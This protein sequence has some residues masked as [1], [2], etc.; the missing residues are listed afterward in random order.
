MGIRSVIVVRRDRLAWLDFA[1]RP[2][3]A[4]RTRVT[5]FRLGCWRAMA[6]GCPLFA[7][8]QRCGHAQRLSLCSRARRPSLIMRPVRPEKSTDLVTPTVGTLLTTFAKAGEVTKA[9]RGYRLPD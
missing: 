8:S 2:V 3:T 6:T 4:D 7:A 1:N 9:Q 5:K